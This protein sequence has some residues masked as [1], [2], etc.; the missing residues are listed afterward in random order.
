MRKR[1]SITIISI[2]LVALMICGWTAYAATS[3]NTATSTSVMG[4]FKSIQSDAVTLQTDS[5]DQTVPLAKSVWVYRDDQKSQLTEL[6]S[7]DRVELI[8]NSKN[9]AAYIKASSAE[10]TET[11][12]AAPVVPEPS[13]KQAPTAA[14]NEIVPTIQP[15]AKQ[16][17]EVYPELSDI[18]LKVDGKNFKLHI[19]QTKSANGVLYDL[20]VKPENA[21]M[22]HLKGEQAANLIKMLLTSID[23]KSSDAEKV[24]AQQLAEHYGL[25]AGKLKVQMKTKWEQMDDEDD[26]KDEDQKYKPNTSKEQSDKHDNR[27]KNEKQHGNGHNN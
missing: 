3:P 22:I 16:D 5:G 4:I 14:S 19:V 18:D 9:Q 24:L 17:K 8:V 25:D 7:G 12:Q 11:S 1:L 6:H 10:A 21:G 2:T 15:P 26:V 20:S 13:P 23:L 27:Q